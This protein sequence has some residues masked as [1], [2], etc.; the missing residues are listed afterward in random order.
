[1]RLQLT[2]ARLRRRRYHVCCLAL[3]CALLV[4][5]NA[6]A[7]DPSK[8][9]GKGEVT[10]RG[11]VYADDDATQIYTSLVDGKV[12][13]P[14][15]TRVGVHALIDVVSTASVDVVSA[16][17]DRF[18]EIRVE[19]GAKAGWLITP[20]MDLTLAFVR[21]AENDWLS[22]APSINYGLDL[23]Q[24]NTRL[25]VAYAFSYNR[26]GRAGDP[27]FE[28]RA[29]NHSA[30]LGLTQVLDK[31][32]LVGL[33]YTFQ[34][35]KGWQSSPYRYVT[36][37]NGLYSF[38]EQHPDERFRHAITATALRYLTKGVGLEASYRFYADSWGVL[39][40]TMTAALRLDLFDHFDARV[41]ARG[42]YQGSTDF[43]RE[44]YDEPMQFMSV[45]RELSNFWD[46]GGGIKLGWY[47][48]N[49]EI[50]AKA[51]VIHYHFIDFS[52]LDTRLA[53]VSDLGAR[54]QW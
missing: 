40:H 17:T 49:W 54:F 18:E 53:V 15:R 13:L 48:D 11:G 42:Y 14:A 12:A 44:H 27:N 37:R 16:A 34:Y 45:D 50:N 7:Q 1:M 30:E 26:V 35:A 19:V 8:D 46:I 25:S 39:A 10:L 23:L 6:S 3:A 41:R 24:R 32:S 9:P 51:D 38:L 29:D 43:W 2:S 52:R 21:S 47:N 22:Y 36:T 5:V 4:V 28:Q 20:E 31:K 33:S